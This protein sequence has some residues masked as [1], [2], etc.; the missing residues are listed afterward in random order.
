MYVHSFVTTY[1]SVS[2]EVLVSFTPTLT[3]LLLL[4]LLLPEIP[5]VPCKHLLGVLLGNLS[6]AVSILRQ[7]GPSCKERKAQ[8]ALNE[9]TAGFTKKVFQVAST[10]VGPRSR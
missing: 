9:R 10:R 6:P 3:V 8:I 1:M 2:K 4:L 7:L 5:M